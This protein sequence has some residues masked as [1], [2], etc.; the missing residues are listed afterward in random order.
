MPKK[1]NKSAD[2]IPGMQD[3]LWYKIKDQERHYLREAFEMLPDQAAMVLANI[4]GICTWCIET[5]PV[6]RG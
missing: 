2:N 1:D 5:I 6:D 3:I 4:L